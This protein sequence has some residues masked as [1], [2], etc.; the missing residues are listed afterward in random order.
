MIGNAFLTIDSGG[1]KTKLTLYGIG[2]NRIRERTTFGF[3]AAEDSES[4]LDEA[5]LIFSDFCKEY[6]VVSAICNLGGKNK[7][8]MEITLRSVFPTS[9]IEVF[10]ESEGVIGLALCEK[11]GAGVT[12]MAGTGS[13]A[14]AKAGSGAVICGGWGA[15]IGDKGSGYQLGLDAIR[16]ALEELDGIGELSLLAKALTG[17]GEAPRTMSAQAY[18]AFRDAVRKKLAPFDRAH[19]ASY[20]KKV[21]ECA[22]LGD[23]GAIALYERV[24]CDLADTVILAAKKRGGAL[25]GVVVNGGMVNAKAFWQNSFEKKLFDVYGKLKIHYLTDGID[26]AMCDMAKRIIKGE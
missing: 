4:I 2:G 20:A 26:E 10:R 3:G 23:K 8:Q 15:N 6:N 19:I 12:L 16:L 14:I 1:S 25:D 9:R 18:C 17:I 21:S 13:I 5:A 7:K 11:Y 24:G 22:S